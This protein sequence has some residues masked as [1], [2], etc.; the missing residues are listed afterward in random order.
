MR[1][2][3]MGS[4]SV[5]A[6][7]KQDQTRCSHDAPQDKAQAPLHDRRDSIIRHGGRFLR[8]HIDHPEESFGLAYM[9]RVSKWLWRDTVIGSPALPDLLRPVLLRMIGLDVRA[10]RLPA[11]TYFG[12]DKLVIGRG[13]SM[14]SGCSLVGSESIEIGEDNI[15][16]PEVMII[17]S[18]HVINADGSVSEV[19]NRPV[20]IGDNCWIG[21]RALIL[22]G[23]T[24]GDGVVIAPGTVVTED[25]E[26][27]A[28]YGGAPARCIQATRSPPDR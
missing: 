14:L 2:T 4:R 7:I 27:H 6:P 19:R 20:R 1:Q 3:A 22:P 21:A 26:P 23:V 5:S 15:F 24:I 11:R 8:W 13:T 25:C 9:A 16:G 28:H 18:E 10:S 17:T 12:T